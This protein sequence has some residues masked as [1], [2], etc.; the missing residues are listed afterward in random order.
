LFVG[1][2]QP[3]AAGREDLDGRRPRKDRLDDIG[4]RAQDVFAIVE[5]E[6]P[7]SSL[8]RRGNAVGQRHARLVSNA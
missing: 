5:K 7:R 2:S 4:G 3:L 8:Q 1:R 6:Q